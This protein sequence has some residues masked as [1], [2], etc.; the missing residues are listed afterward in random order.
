MTDTAIPA[1][2]WRRLAAAIYDGLLLLGIW[3]V[4]LLIDT[5]V[6][7]A[8]GLERE[9]HALRAFLFLIGLAFFGWFWTHGGQTLGM[10]AWR[11]KLRRIDGRPPGW[12]N[13]TVRYAVMLLSWGV[14]LTP[15]LMQLPLYAGRPGAMRIAALAV[16]AVAAALVLMRLD[17]RRRTPQDYAAQCEMIELPKT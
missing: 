13:A 10:R 6:R 2:L 8:L 5:V 11:L 14:A 3:M 9:W 15:L 12:V 4:C 1:S 16:V 7:D 17:P